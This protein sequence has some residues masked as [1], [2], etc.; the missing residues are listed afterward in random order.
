MI[1][2]PDA[3]VDSVGLHR[4]EEQPEAIAAAQALGRAIGEMLGGE[5]VGPTK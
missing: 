3:S 2:G 4:F 1:F 5:G